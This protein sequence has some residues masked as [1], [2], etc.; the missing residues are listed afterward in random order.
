VLIAAILAADTS[1][2]QR[3][4]RE[5]NTTVAFLKQIEGELN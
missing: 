3:Q 4:M 2:I 1:N 5:N